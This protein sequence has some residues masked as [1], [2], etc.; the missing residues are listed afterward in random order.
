MYALAR[1]Y[2]PRVWGALKEHPVFR[3]IGESLGPSA[4]RQIASEVGSE[5]D[6]VWLSGD[7]REAT[8]H[9][10]SD[11][12]EILAWRVFDRLGVPLEHQG[13][14]V[15]TLTRHRLISDDGEHDQR[16][17]QLMGSPTSFPFL[18]LYNAAVTRLAI[19]TSSPGLPPL[20]L[21]SY[22]MLVNGDDLLLGC[23]SVT[24]SNWERVVGWAGLLPSVGKTLVSR[25]YATINSCLYRMYPRF[26]HQ[27][28]WIEPVRLPHIQLQ[29]A[30]GSMKSGHTDHLSS[31]LAMSDPCSDSRMWHE[32]L[33]SCPQREPAW[34]FLYSAN[35]SYIRALCAGFPTSTLCLPP[36]AGGLGFPL[37]PPSSVYYPSRKPRTRDMMLGRM[38]LEEGTD[39]HSR[40]RSQWLSTL[41]MMT[42]QSPVQQLVM[43]DWSKAVSHCTGDRLF[44]PSEEIEDFLPPPDIAVGLSNSPVVDWTTVELFRRCRRIRFQLDRALINYARSG[45][46]PLDLRSLQIIS[47]QGRWVSRYMKFDF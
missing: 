11:F 6:L 22:P 13:P 46:G 9:I 32:F 1:D 20:S 19:E 25:Q 40:L 17:G 7:Y 33:D 4:M 36:E 37:P 15:A 21:D 39:A 42:L 28:E 30:I 16:C 47:R 8:D 3:L 41:R 14:L 5:Q 23:S 12:A 10:P 38:L 26:S 43:S 31:S 45:R 24:Y 18:C 29:L 27:T 2:Q 44:R 34:R 35:R